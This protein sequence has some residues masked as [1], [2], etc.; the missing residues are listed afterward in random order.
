MVQTPA[1][2]LAAPA[3]AVNPRRLRRDS[4]SLR[5][6]FLPALFTRPFLDLL[7]GEARCVGRARDLLLLGGG[8]V[9]G[10]WI[11]VPVHELLHAL[12]CMAAGGEVSRLE[13][14]PLYGGALLER[15]IPWVAAGDEYAGRLSGFD[16]GGSDL[17]YLA[18]D[19]GPFVLVLFPGVWALRRAARAG[20]PELFG[21]ALPFALA[22]LLSLTGDAYEI[23]SI[24]LTR[25]P[26]WAG[27]AARELLRGD[28]L[29]RVGEAVAAAGTGVA[30]AGFA[31]AALLGTLWAFATYALGG[32]LAARL[33]ER[34]LPPPPRPGGEAEPAESEAA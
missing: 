29:F 33:G 12:A 13:I 6:V 25:V 14:A 26:P 28:D 32:W 10:W 5:P 21:L 17:V 16:T 3:R 1:P 7:R 30:W 9:V 19:L 4:G 11:Y 2:I 24:V 20:R 34:P 8:L 15:G 22:P 31:L 23:G 27:E 18:T